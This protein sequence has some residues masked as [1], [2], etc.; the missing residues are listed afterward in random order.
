MESS[1]VESVSI[2]RS[3]P[4]NSYDAKRHD[5]DL[6]TRP[7][8]V[9]LRNNNYKHND[10]FYSTPP[11]LDECAEAE[12]ELLLAAEMVDTRNHVN[13]STDSVADC[14]LT[15]QAPSRRPNKLLVKSN[16]CFSFY[17]TSTP[18]PIR[19]HLERQLNRKKLFPS[20]SHPDTSFVFTDD[21]Q[22]NGLLGSPTAENNRRQWRRRDPDVEFKWPLN[23]EFSGS[24]EKKRISVLRSCSENQLKDLSGKSGCANREDNNYTIIPV[25]P[26]ISIKVRHEPETEGVNGQRQQQPQQQPIKLETAVDGGGVNV[27]QREENEVLVAAQKYFQE[28]G[29]FAMGNTIFRKSS[30]VHV[31]DNV[32]FE[33]VGKQ[34]AS[35]NG[36][37][38]DT[39]LFVRWVTRFSGRNVGPSY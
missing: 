29:I 18:S 39:G 5:N 25:H 34:H 37:T 19:R 21:P 4:V 1:K 7:I 23:R 22:L 2:L 11:P 10:H 31:I 14:P 12:N 24:G 17:E 28:S 9:P 15:G 27:G 20:F 38:G 26:E 30:K 33:Q 36:R 16:T 35:S 32:Q 8:A 13:L 3:H 6:L